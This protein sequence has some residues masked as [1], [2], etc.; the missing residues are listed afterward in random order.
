AV[1]ALIVVGVIVLAVIIFVI[2]NYN[3]LVAVRQHLRDSWSGVD[4]E[5]KRR[6]DLI[7]N[8]VEV[9]KG[10]A[11]HERE[12]F[13]RVAEARARAAANHGPQDSQASDENAMLGVLGRLFAIAE[14]Y[15]ELRSDER[16]AELQRQLSLTEDRIAASRRFY[17]ANVREMNQLRMSFPTNLVGSAFGF[18]TQ[19]FFELDEAVERVTPR[20]EL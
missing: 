8:L 16:Y 15:P 5:L 10:Y 9:V 1:I 14:A 17:N 2:G 18:H 11:A 19:R 7:P 3:R 4:V 12:L 6:Y 13:E 20:I